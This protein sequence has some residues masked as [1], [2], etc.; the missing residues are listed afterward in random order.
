MK[1]SKVLRA[2]EPKIGERVAW[3]FMWYRCFSAPSDGCRLCDMCGRPVCG[4]VECSPTRRK[5]GKAVIF[6]REGHYNRKQ[7]NEILLGGRIA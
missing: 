2:I 4:M 7:L 6:I 3:N 5:D 1:E